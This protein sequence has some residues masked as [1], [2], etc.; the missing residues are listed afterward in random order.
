MENKIKLF[1][2]KNKIKWLNY[3]TIIFGLTLS[4]IIL[5]SFFL[6]SSWFYPLLNSDDALN[7]LMAH[8]YKLPDDFYCWGQDRGGTLIPL[9]SQLFIKLF[10]CSAL[11]AVSLSNYLVL[12]LGYF[13]LSSLIKSRYYKIIFAIIWFLPFQRFVDITRF[14]IGVE[15]SIIGAAIYL[16]NKLDSNR[17]AFCNTKRKVLLALIILLFIISIWVSDLSIVTIA[18][19][20]SVLILYHYIEFKSI[21]IDKTVIIYAV[22]GLVSCFLFIK[23]AKSFA[24]VKTHNYLEINGLTQ[25]KEAMLILKDAFADVLL[26]KQNEV[27]VSVYVYFA[28]AFFVYLAISVL[29][30]KNVKHLLS[31][32]WIVFFLVDTVAIFSVIILSSWVL[33]NNMGRWYFVATYISLSMTVV[34]I[35][36][37]I[38]KCKKSL[39]Y[40]IL[41]LVTIGAVSPV[42]NMKYVYPKRL[43][44]MTKVVG[45]FQQ[46]GEIGVIGEFW[47]SYRTSC[48]APDII[49]ATPHDKSNV[50]NYKLAEMVFEK[51]DIYV[52]KDMWLP[53]FPDTLN[54]FGHVLIKSGV[55]FIIGDCNVCRYDKVN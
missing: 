44:P 23:Y 51:N 21:K 22:V 8:Y 38:E 16:I 49:V 32:K 42:F 36:D 41:V 39:R 19:L 17:N 2:S 25:I 33:A 45:E 43:T 55:P 14:P 53:E 35:L 20:I 5:G 3:R 4:L 12:I 13:G 15:Y 34:L 31:N 26:L 18:I 52:I 47:N 54:Q 28:I 1:E 50:R 11:T 10:G 48:T 30:G 29:R 7:I 40:G 9:L 37:N 27:S 46:L 6:Y 24:V